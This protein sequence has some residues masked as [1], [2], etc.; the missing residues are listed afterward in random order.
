MNR[1][2]WS[3]A[4]VPFIGALILFVATIAI[5]ILNGIDVYTPDHDTLIGHVHAGTLGWITQSFAAVAI[6]VFIGDRT[7]GD[8]DL[9]RARTMARWV[10]I[11]VTLY[12]AAFFAGDAVPGDRIDRPITGTLLLLMLI[13]FTRWMFQNQRQVPKTIARL[14]L[15][16]SGIAVVIGAVFGIVLGVVTAGQEIPGLSEKLTDAIAEVHPPAMVVGFLLLAAMAMIEWLLGDRPA[17]GNRA[18]VIQMWLVFAAGLLLTVAFISGLEEELAGPANLA[19]IVGVVM[20]LVRRRRDLKPAAWKGS[21]TAWFPRTSLLFLL[22]YLVLLTVIVAKFVSGAMDP[23]AMTP[24]DDGLLV[25]LDHMMFVGV[26][27]TAL[28][29]ALAT[30]LHGKAMGVV[31][32][33]LLGGVAIGLPGFVV[34][35]ITLEQ[36]PK[37]IFTPIMG[38]ALLIGIFGYLREVMRTGANT[39]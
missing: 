31:D 5:G 1:Q 2:A 25:A 33:I 10:T 39:S 20:L 11:A 22:G 38:T 12:V 18:G 7:L 17:A 21:G 3:V 23:D 19:M 30:T 29:G 28:F 24:E 16:L 14:G 34:G 9:K 35:L 27:T 15:L 6:L 4:R 32:K 26:M 36:L 8:A 13:W 37:R